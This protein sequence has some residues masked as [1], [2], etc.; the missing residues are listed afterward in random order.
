MTQQIIK[1]LQVLQELGR[2]GGRPRAPS[3]SA[4]HPPPPELKES[5]TSVVETEG[6]QIQHSFQTI[7]NLQD[8]SLRDH[9]MEQTWE[10]STLRSSEGDQREHREV[11]NHFLPT[12][13]YTS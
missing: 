8:D 11:P 6:F 2:A 5:P 13:S 9:R 3:G 7:W 1:T 4:S 12:S 10:A